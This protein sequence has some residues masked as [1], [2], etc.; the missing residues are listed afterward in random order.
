MKNNQMEIDAEATNLSIKMIEIKS[1]QPDAKQE[2]ADSAHSQISR[3]QSRYGH[4]FFFQ[5]LIS[6]K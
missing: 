3:Y 4:N 6:Y 5:F 1:K 2:Q